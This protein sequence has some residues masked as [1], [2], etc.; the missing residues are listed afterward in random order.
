VEVDETYVG[1]PKPGKTGRGAGGK[2]TRSRER[3]RAAA[4]GQGAASR[5]PQAGRGVPDVS[6]KSLEGF[7]AAAV[8]KPAIVATDGWSR[9][10]ASMRPAMP[11]N[12]S[13]T[14]WSPSPTQLETHGYPVAECCI[15]SDRL[16]VAPDAAPVGVAG[17]QGRRRCGWR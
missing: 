2:I 1:A 5:P 3:S 12:R 14:P 11:T 15:S 7:L 4:A 10:S 6:A 17:R 8:A 16:L 13:T 9:Y